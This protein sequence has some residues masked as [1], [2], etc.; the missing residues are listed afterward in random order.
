MPDERKPIIVAGCGRSGTHWLGNI[1]RT[2][3]GRERAGH[4]P[5]EYGSHQWKALHMDVIVDSRL[6]RYISELKADGCRILHLTRDGRDV[7]RSLMTWHAGRRT[8]EQ[9]CLEWRDAINAM[10]EFP[11]VK[12]EDLVRPKDAREHVFPAWQEWTD[13]QRDMFWRICERPMERL[14]YLP[15]GTHRGDPADQ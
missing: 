9:C 12:L 15:W 4:E 5:A 8:F 1:F 10:T 13:E 11:Q 7:V 2:I 14:G 3:M 6:R